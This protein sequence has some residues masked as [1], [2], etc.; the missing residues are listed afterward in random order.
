[1]KLIAD[2][3]KEHQRKRRQYMDKAKEILNV[4]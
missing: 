1:V 3:V 4:K 2:F